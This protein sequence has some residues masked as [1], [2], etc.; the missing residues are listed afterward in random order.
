LIAESSAS[1][2]T[3][4][5][6]VHPS[7]NDEESDHGTI[8]EIPEEFDTPQRDQEQSFTMAP[9][10][11]SLG[12][13]VGPTETIQTPA[14]DKGKG[15]K[16]DPPPHLESDNDEWERL[17]NALD[18]CET[19]AKQG[20]VQA[21]ENRQELENLRSK[22]TNSYNRAT[23]A[24]SAI[25][26]VRTLYER[27]RTKTGKLQRSE[28]PNSPRAMANRALFAERRS[29]EESLDY[30]RRLH[31]QARFDAPQPSEPPKA[32]GNDRQLTAQEKYAMAMERS[33][34]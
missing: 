18:H 10:S 30:N 8:H 14:A 9:A 32:A 20:K 12:L 22:V 17:A 6:E 24:I 1:E 2:Q 16:R 34:A 27:L 23:Y 7:N 26:E 28:T 21:I 3:E 13:S 15:R 29:D 11:G 5:E 33:R 31:A 19:I 25:S 4:S